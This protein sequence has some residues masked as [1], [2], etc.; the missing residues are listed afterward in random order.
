MRPAHTC[1]SAS[2]TYALCSLEIR[3]IGGTVWAS[4]ETPTARTDGPVRGPRNDDAELADEMAEQRKNGTGRRDGGDREGCGMTHPEPLEGPLAHPN[5][6]RGRRK[7]I[8][9]TCEL[10]RGPVGFANLL[11]SMQGGSIVFDPHVTGACV[12]SLG[13]ESAKT[14]RNTLTEWLG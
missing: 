11:V 1:W 2:G 13:E 12:I 3:S 4:D 14:L 10:H 5:P 6:P 8:P 9:A 7:A